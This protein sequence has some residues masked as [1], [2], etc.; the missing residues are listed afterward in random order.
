MLVLIALNDSA[1]TDFPELLIIKLF[2][3]SLCPIKPSIGIDVTFSK[4][5]L[6]LIV[7]LKKSL[8]DITVI[9]V[10]I[11]KNIAMK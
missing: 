4:S 3:L 9:G 5:L 7:S 6:L 2:A 1:I 11:P 10:S 8:I